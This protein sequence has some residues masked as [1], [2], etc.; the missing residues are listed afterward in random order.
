MKLITDTARIK[1]RQL[2]FHVTMKIMTDTGRIIG[3]ATLVSCDD[4]DNDIY[5]KNYREGSSCFM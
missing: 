2:L 4:E 5:R 3:K 1:G